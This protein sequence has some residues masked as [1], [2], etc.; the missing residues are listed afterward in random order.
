M[1]VLRVAFE[2]KSRLLGSHSKGFHFTS[3]GKNEHIPGAD[4]HCSSFY[5]QSVACSSL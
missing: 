4:S 3:D 1:I 5:L 2:V